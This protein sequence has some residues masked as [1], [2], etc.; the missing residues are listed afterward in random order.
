MVLDAGICSGFRRPHVRGL[1]AGTRS[2]S[3]LDAVA[4]TCAVAAIAGIAT[5]VYM[6]LRIG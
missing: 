2:V 6:I 3:F 5:L 4:I 1:I